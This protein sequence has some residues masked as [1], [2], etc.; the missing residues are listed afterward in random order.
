MTNP[1]EL[2][3]RH[4]PRPDS[5]RRGPLDLGRT[6]RLAALL[7]RLS[8]RLTRAVW[9]HGLG[10]V[11]VVTV[12]WMAFAFFADWALHV[13]RAVRWLH[14]VLLFGLPGYVLWRELVR[15]LARRPDRAGLAVLLERAHPELH[16][17]IVSAVQLQASPDGSPALVDRVLARAEETAEKLDLAHVLDTRGPRRRVALGGAAALLAVVAG[18]AAPGHT[19]IFVNRLFGGGASWPQ[20]THLAVSIPLVEERARIDATPERI[21]VRVARGTDVPILVRAQGKVPDDVT[22]HFD[23]GQELLLSPGGE[24]AFRT[25]LRSCQESLAFHVTG[26]DDQRG[27]PRVEIEVLQPPDIAGIAVRIEPPAYTGEE[28]RVEFDLD[29]SVPA[30]SRLSIAMLPEPAGAVGSVRILPDDTVLELAPRPFPVRPTDAD[31]SGAPAREGL[32]FEWTADASFRYRFELRDETGLRNPDPGLFAV[33]VLEDRPPEVQVLSPARSDFHTT[34]IGAL[35]LRVRVEDD[36]GVDSLRYTAR[37]AGDEASPALRGDLE[38]APVDR[39]DD[40]WRAGRAGLVVAAR[41]RLEIA[42]LLTQLSAGTDSFGQLVLNIEARDNRPALP[43]VDGAEAADASDDPGIGKA[44][45]V[46][47]RI[48]PGDE[49]LRRVQDRLARVR[50]QAAALEELERKKEQ[51]VRELLDAIES[52]DLETLEN[53]NELA[54]ALSGERRVQGDA[55]ALARE[56]ASIVETVL[57]ARLDDKAGALL[58]HVDSALAE[59]HERSFSAEPWIDL[60]A[61]YAAGRLGSPAF[62]GQLVGILDL[63]LKL[64]E[65]DTQAAVEALDR[66]GLAVDVPEVHAALT[67]AAAAQ[68]QALSRLQDLL[69]RLAEWDNF[70]SILSLTRDILNQQKSL[71]DRTRHLAREK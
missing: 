68:R 8:S 4:D 13:P 16:E 67:D 24:G 18:L 26:G 36:H 47:V 34:S 9:L 35:S 44:P 71:A 3:S 27:L 15:P 58:E 46:R 14:L 53:S 54:A 29:V 39:E 33:H 40:D 20:R 65:E 52:D 25:I 1:R 11:L 55:A 42:D 5:R 6:P 63:S 31:V 2:D 49:L 37:I 45:P 50:T 66:A 41:R 7:D 21:H 57:Y 30:G 19:A 22:V 17:L 62:A 60:T 48:V 64:S 10:S 59:R 28:A 56:V 23:S 12:L 43:G 69:D 32:G 38:F 51:R 61:A 70:Q